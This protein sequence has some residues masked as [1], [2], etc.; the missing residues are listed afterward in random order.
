MDRHLPN[1]ARQR[2]RQPPARVDATEQHVG[3]RRAALLA[4]APRHERGSD[5][6]DD[7][8]EFVGAPAHDDENSRH[9]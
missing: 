6:V 9:T 4:R 1:P 8:G 2:H 7:V 3:D 5:L